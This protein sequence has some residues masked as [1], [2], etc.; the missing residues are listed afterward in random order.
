[1]EVE[2]QEELRG[3]RIVDFGEGSV[4]LSLF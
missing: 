4:G 2:S 1:L 3:K